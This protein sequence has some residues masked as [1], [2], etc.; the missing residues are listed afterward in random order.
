[1]C[2][3]LLDLVIEKSMRTFFKKSEKYLRIARGHAI[4]SPV[5]AIPTVVIVVVVAIAVGGGDAET[6]G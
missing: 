3:R 6:G 4:G 5:S 2:G 1:M